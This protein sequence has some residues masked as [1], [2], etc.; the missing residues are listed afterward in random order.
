MKKPNPQMANSFL[1][2][3]DTALNVMHTRAVQLAAP[4]PAP[5]EREGTQ[6]YLCFSLSKDKDHL[7][8]F[9]FRQVKEVLASNAVLVT[10]LPLVPAY[11]TGTTNYRGALISLIDLRTL[12]ALPDAAAEAENVVIIRSGQ[13]TIGFM[14]GFIVTS[15]PYHPAALTGAPGQSGALQASYVAGLHQGKIALLNVAAMVQDYQLELKGL[16]LSGQH[17]QLA[18][19]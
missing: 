10:A 6:H 13:M 1:P 14:V 19:R 15:Q 9:D 8:G 7:F 2:Q 5:M 3:S 17:V 16:A 12:F 18:T 4:P 11:V